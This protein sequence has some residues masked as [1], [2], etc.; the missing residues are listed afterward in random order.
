MQQMN[1]ATTSI[2][3]GN[4][5]HYSVITSFEDDTSSEHIEIETNS[6]YSIQIHEESTR[7]YSTSENGDALY[8]TIEETQ[9]PIQTAAEDN[10]EN[11]ED[12]VIPSLN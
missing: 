6:A 2:T 11:E 4:T 8:S 5:S 7:H 3:S 9:T 1:V 10:V 12:Y